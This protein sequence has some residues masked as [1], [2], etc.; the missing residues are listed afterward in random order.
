MRELDRLDQEQ[1]LGAMPGTTA[2]RRRRGPSQLLVGLIVAALVGGVVLFHPSESMQSVR[3]MLGL[4][5]DRLLSAPA[6]VGADSG[7]FDFAMTQQGSAD[8]VGWD[9]CRPIKY[10]VDPAG[11]PP[12]GAALIDSAIERASAATGLAFEDTGDTDK[13]PFTGQIVQFGD[14]PV[15]IGWG[16]EDE[17]P[18]LGGAVAGLGGGSAQEGTTGRRYYVTGGVVLDTQAFT[19]EAIARR[20]QVMEAIVLHELAHVVG[21]GHVSEPLELM[22]E[23]NVGQVDFG[24]GDLEGLARLGSLPCR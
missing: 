16:D 21:L 2:P 24:P 19:A 6:S 9:P 23:S 20:P 5:P 7:E 11:E 14:R 12:G 3:R 4:G 13:R 10:A 18:E 17:F 15:V 8:P 22:F 1:G